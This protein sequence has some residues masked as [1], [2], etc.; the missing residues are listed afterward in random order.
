[1]NRRE[2]FIQSKCDRCGKTTPAK[3]NGIGDLFTLPHEYADPLSDSGDFCEKC[4]ERYDEDD[5][6]AW[7]REQRPEDF[8]TGPNLTDRRFR[9]TSSA[10][11]DCYDRMDEEELSLEE[12]RARIRLIELCITIASEYGDEV[13]EE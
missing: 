2:R 12:H 10:L 8:E 4:I 1:M 11:A 9:N 7:F 6:M 13:T 3:Q 5:W